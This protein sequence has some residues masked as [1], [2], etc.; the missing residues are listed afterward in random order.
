MDPS[1]IGTLTEQ[2][3]WKKYALPGRISS[4]QARHGAN[5]FLRGQLWDLGTDGQPFFIH[6]GKLI[7]IQEAEKGGIW[8]LYL[9]DTGD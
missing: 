3:A 6:Q 2:E 7:D 9:A 1:G 5:I 8:N 4:T